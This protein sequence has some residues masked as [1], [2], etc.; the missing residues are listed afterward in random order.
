M[1]STF[2][3]CLWQRFLYE[4]NLSMRR[5]RKLHSLKKDLST[6]FEQ[7]IAQWRQFLQLAPVEIYS[8]KR[9]WKGDNLEK[10][11]KEL[12]AQVRGRQVHLLKVC[13]PILLLSKAGCFFITL[14]LLTS[15][16]G[17]S[18]YYISKGEGCFDQKIIIFADFQYYLCWCWWLGWPK[19]G[20]KHADII[21]GWSLRPTR[22]RQLQPKLSINEPKFW[23]N[24][25]TRL[26]IAV[27]L[28]LSSVDY[29]R[30]SLWS[31]VLA[32]GLGE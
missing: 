17:P 13:G 27:F 28:A 8:N 31:F 2:K 16:L 32:L 12:K 18:I 30:K 21:Y 1:G 5:G 24:G 22:S 15:P 11:F 9:S 26:K 23:S 3:V 14:L 4:S 7:R 20:H 19:K 25:K 29:R 6:Y 10:Q